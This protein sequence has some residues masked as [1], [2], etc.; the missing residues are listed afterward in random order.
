MTLTSIVTNPRERTR[1]FRFAVVGIIGAVVD[2][3][4]FNLLTSFASLSAVLASIF[5]FIAAIIN[6]FTWNRYWTYPDSRSKPLGR[7]LFQFS[8]VSI[9]GLIIRTPI[10]AV[11]AP[12]FNRLF[13]ELELLP[14]G[15]LTAEFLANNLALAIAVIVVMFWNFF[16]N[17]Y[18]TYSDVE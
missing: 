18:W 1:F 12:F 15:F 5:S 17:R 6:N 2:F 7:Q 14:I 4:T 13:S 16:F 3:G 11:L 10:I 9:L 8:T